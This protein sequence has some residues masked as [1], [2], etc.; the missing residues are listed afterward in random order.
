MLYITSSTN[1]IIRCFTK[2]CREVQNK[3]GQ[4]GF[5]VKTQAY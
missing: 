4:T 5:D 2:L 1:K 3:A